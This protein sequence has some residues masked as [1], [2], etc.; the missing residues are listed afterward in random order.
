MDIARQ[1]VRG[2]VIVRQLWTFQ[3]FVLVHLHTSSTKAEGQFF[4]LKSFWYRSM[5]CLYLIVT[6]DKRLLFFR[7]LSTMNFGKVE[8]NRVFLCLQKWLEVWPIDALN[9]LD[10]RS[11]LGDWGWL[12]STVVAFTENPKILIT[13][14]VITC[15]TKNASASKS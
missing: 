2:C 3:I 7:N 14:W 8:A 1:G 5:I 4:Y 12:E 13:E 15:G 10:Y 9:L 6:V 11:H